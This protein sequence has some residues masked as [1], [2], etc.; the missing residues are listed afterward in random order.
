MQAVAIAHR[1][2]ESS[3]IRNQHKNVSRGVEHGR[4]VPAV[5]KVSFDRLAQIGVNRSLD[6]VRDLAPNVFAI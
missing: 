3:I 6:V 4:A 2:F 1:E 5:S